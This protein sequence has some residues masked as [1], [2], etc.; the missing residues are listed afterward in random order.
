MDQKGF[1]HFCPIHT[2]KARELLGESYL[3][4]WREEPET[5]VYQRERVFIRSDA[6]LELARDL[7]LPRILIRLLK[8]VPVSI[9]DRVYSWIARHRYQLFGKSEFCLRPESRDQSRFLG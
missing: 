8:R 7:G 3:S 2:E 5:V 6:I 1:I 4:S 9:R